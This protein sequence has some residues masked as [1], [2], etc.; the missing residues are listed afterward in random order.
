MG[1]R[2]MQN[3]FGGIFTYPVAKWTSRPDVTIYA[4]QDRDG[5]T[6][7]HL[8]TVLIQ[9]RAYVDRMVQL[10]NARPNALQ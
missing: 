4:T 10:Q 6:V 1:T 2:Q 7:T 9:D 5:E 3:G 8:T